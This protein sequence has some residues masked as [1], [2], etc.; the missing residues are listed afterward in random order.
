MAHSVLGRG[1]FAE[2]YK[3]EA[4]IPPGLKAVRTKNEPEDYEEHSIYEGVPYEGA[5]SSL[6]PICDEFPFMKEKNG[7]F[8]NG[9]LVVEMDYDDFHTEIYKFSL[10]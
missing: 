9:N 10:S 8:H 6:R 2:V 7:R 4:L 1:G 3:V 5:P